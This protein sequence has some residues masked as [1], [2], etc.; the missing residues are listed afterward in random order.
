MD[1]ISYIKEKVFFA[2]KMKQNF[3]KIYLRENTF[4]TPDDI[5]AAGFFHYVFVSALEAKCQ[6]ESGA[7][8]KIFIKN[9]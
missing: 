4:F 5:E 6:E 1:K 8:F 3:A 7:Y 2:T 9:V